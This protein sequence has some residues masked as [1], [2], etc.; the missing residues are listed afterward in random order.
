MGLKETETVFS[1]VRL[2]MA[3]AQAGAVDSYYMNGQE[4]ELT[5]TLWQKDGFYEF[6][7]PLWPCCLRLDHA[8]VPPA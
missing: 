3:G 5:L 2:R 6:L 8:G 1:P 4:A 7:G